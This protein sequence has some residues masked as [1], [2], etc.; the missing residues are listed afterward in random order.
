MSAFAYRALAADGQVAEGRVEAASRAE[1]IAQLTASG[2]TL[3]RLREQAGAAH[4]SSRPDALAQVRIPAR[5]RET[6]F[7][8]L[9]ALLAAGVPLATAL[10]RLTRETRHRAAGKVWKSLHDQVADGTALA[11]AMTRFPGVFPRVSTAMVRAGETGGFLDPVLAQIAEFQGRDRDLRS[12]VIGALVYPSILAVLSMA[13]VAFLLTFFIPK[14]QGMFEDFGG[15]LPILTRAIIVVSGWV[16]EW[17]L[18]LLALLGAGL[19]VLR[20]WVLSERGRRH[21]EAAWLRLPVIGVLTARLAMTRFCRMLGTLTGAGVPLVNALGV[22]SQSLG[23]Q[24]LVDAVR[25]AVKHVRQGSRLADSL[26]G[27]PILFPGSVIEIVAVAEQTGKLDNELVRLA[28]TSEKD[29]NRN[30]Q[31]AVALAEPAMLFVM[32]CVVGMIVIGMVLPIF[33][34]QEYIR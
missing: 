25:D 13:V 17:G 23:N 34:L 24:I 18:L 15:T 11:D 21:W 14:F 7:R 28:E 27:C 19:L 16:R 26:A 12:K 33:T 10:S 5:I 29:L 1:A 6:F 30:L 22:A 31:L 2:L 8:Q 9:S 32:A 3:L 4:P 20:G